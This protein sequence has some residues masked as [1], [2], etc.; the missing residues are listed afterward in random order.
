[1]KKVILRMNEELKYK[2]IK[3]LVDTNGNKLRAAI[4]L[5]CTQRHINR[6]IQ[7]YKREGK[8]FFLHGNRDKSP[9]NALPEETKSFIAD[10]Y[11]NKFFDA[12]Y[13]H[14]TELL[15]ELEAIKVSS[16]T[17]HKILKDKGFLSP[18]AHRKTKKRKMK[19]L[20]AIKK[21]A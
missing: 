2:I 17:V 5:G 21:A 16:G 12:N 18:K 6:M 20:I 8:I 14:F 11:A 19:E 3:K 10:L 9:S 4:E 7:G 15:W 13:K 1:M